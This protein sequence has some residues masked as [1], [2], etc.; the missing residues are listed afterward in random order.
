LR[1]VFL[2]L[3]GLLLCSSAWAEKR[4]ALVVGNAVY[5]TAGTLSNPRNDATDIAGALRK[6]EFQVTEHHDLKVRDF[7]QALSSFA[8]TAKGADVALFFYAGHGLTIDKRGFLV[9]TDF[10]AASASTA[11]RELVA[12]D[13]VISQIEHAAKASVIIFDACRD[14]PIADRFRRIA[15]AENRALPSVGLAPIAPSTLGSNTLVV[16]ATVFGEVASDGPG[17]NSPFTSALLKHIET[18]GLEIQSVLTRVTKDVVN[19]TN[20]KQQPERVSRLQTELVFLSTASQDGRTTVA[21][22]V[23][24]L[25]P[26]TVPDQEPAPRRPEFY[27]QVATHPDQIGAMST[28]A[29]LK[30]RYSQVL[31]DNPPSVRKVDLGAKGIWYRVLI[32]PFPTM[33]GAGELC[34]RLKGAGMACLSR[35]E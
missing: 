30:Q 13:A 7:D 16:F 26:P 29:N 24:P 12:I 20:A 2:L 21:A 11:F 4:V 33:G 14:S 31:G 32:G 25:V 6:M 9:P 19:A 18:P 23:P 28:L 15:V 3:T 22:K 5:A 27:V 34:G 1:Q 17:R 10:A 8:Q 35:K